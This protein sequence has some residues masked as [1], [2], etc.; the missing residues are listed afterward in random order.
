[1]NCGKLSK[2]I[3]LYGSRLSVLNVNFI[4]SRK[5]IMR[6]PSEFRHA[7]LKSFSQGR[8]LKKPHIYSSP[9]F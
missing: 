1:M 4:K 2:M 5:K 7:H 8:T 3:L 9:I 6:I